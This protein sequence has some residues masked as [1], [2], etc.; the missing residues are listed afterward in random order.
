VTRARALR[1]AVLAAAAAAAATGSAGAQSFSRIGDAERFAAIV[2]GR[3]LVSADG[4]ESFRA[5]ADGG[6]VAEIGGER[7]AGSW[8]WFE[9]RMCRVLR[10]EEGTAAHCARAAIGRGRLRLYWN[11]GGATE[12]LLR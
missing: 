10:R 4:A 1:A 5:R 12:Y 8:A 9:D 11:E 3:D 6:L 7:Y 2:V